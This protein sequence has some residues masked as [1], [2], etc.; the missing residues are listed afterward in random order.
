MKAIVTFLSAALEPNAFRY[1]V[2]ERIMLEVASKDPYEIVRIM[3]VMKKAY[4]RNE[5]M[6]ATNRAAAG[7]NERRQE[8]KPL[9]TK[10]NEQQASPSA[11]AMSIFG[12][13]VDG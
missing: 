9:A 2:R 13:P 11:P 1:K 4:V 7:R 3:D 10:G 6:E 8:D 12:A 5:G